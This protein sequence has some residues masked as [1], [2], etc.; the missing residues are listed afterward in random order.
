MTELAIDLSNYTGEV[1]VQ[2]ARDLYAA[3]VRRAIV[4]IV[5]DRA[6]VTLGDG[7][8]VLS[9]QQQ[10]PALLAAGIEVECYVYV[11]FSA[12]EVWAADRVGWALGEAS[13]FIGSRGFRNLMWLDCEQSDHDDPPFDYVHAPVSPTIRACVARVKGAGFQP[14]IYTAA[15]WWIP[16]AS[17]SREWSDLPLWDAHYDLDPDLDPVDYGGW[18]VPRYSQYQGNAAIGS[19]GSIDLNSYEAAAAVPAP[20]PPKVQLHLFNRETGQGVVLPEQ[21]I[22]TNGWTAREIPLGALGVFDMMVEVK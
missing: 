14:G 10:I 12:G 11:W 15:W 4:Q 6:F 9:H 13:K 7:S 18:T 22:E 20:E 2:E 21:R 17:N 19:V 3:G 16:G 5:H 1:T 8:R